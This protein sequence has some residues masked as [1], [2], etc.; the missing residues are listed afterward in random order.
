MTANDPDT[1]SLPGL[2]AALRDGRISA[3]ELVEHA[4]S[5]HAACDDRYR[6]YFAWTGD[7]ALAVAD[8]V[9]GLLALGH[10]T[11]PLMGLPVSVK[12][13][14]GV[15]GLRTYAGSPEALPARWEAPGPLV[16]GLLGQL[17]AIMGKTHTVEFAF[18]GLG[19]N[20]HWGTPRNPWDSLAHRVPGGSSSGAGV[21]LLESSAR[22]ALGTDTAG[23]V[24]VPAAMTGVAGLKTTRGL[25]SIEG[26]V[27]LSPS[28]DTPG[29]L[30]RDVTDLAFGFRAL[31]GAPQG[32]PHDHSPAP[33]ALRLGV[34][35]TFFWDDCSPGV[36]EA[37]EAALAVLERAGAVL[38]P[39]DLPHAAE[40]FEILR[41]GGLAASEL[42]AFLE[43]ESP[44]HL[45]TLDANVAARVRAAEALPATA[46]IQRLQ[47]L[48]GMSQDAARALATVDAIVT[49]TV[50]V[51][52]P[53]LDDVAD[54]AAYGRHNVLALRNTMV[55]NMMNLCGLTLP[56]GVDAAGMPVGLQLLAGPWREA[57][58]LRLGASLEGVLGCGADLPGY[59]L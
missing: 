1:L 10:D 18:G 48:Q 56:V 12:E 39:L 15:P 9:D 19:V 43:Q 41:A 31:T 36:A 46:Y 58:L 16:Q 25:F 44:G 57:H 20:A 4:A 59:P 30:A 47:R 28:L 26:I 55:A 42:A 27:P 38:V 49:P 3:R 21:S 29:L 52:P 40:A 11:G 32:S 8:H 45:H 22:L 33:R 35:R 6:A 34:P 17:A 54:P 37:V 23:S 14:Y 7:R 5:R 2:H 13:L 51:T 50:A 53:R 24:R